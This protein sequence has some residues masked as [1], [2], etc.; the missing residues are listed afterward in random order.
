MLFSPPC[1]IFTSLH[2]KTRVKEWCGGGQKRKQF[3]QNKTSL[4]KAHTGSNTAGAPICPVKNTHT[5]TGFFLYL[6]FQSQTL[7]CFSCCLF[8]R[9][10]LFSVEVSQRSLLFWHLSRFAA[11]QKIRKETSIHRDQKGRE[12]WDGDR[13]GGEVEV[14]MQQHLFISPLK[15]HQQT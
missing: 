15:F 9:R 6:Q 10:D 2:E 4:S 14:T 12:G 5:H 7:R 13:R 3:L 1:F 8:L 11:V